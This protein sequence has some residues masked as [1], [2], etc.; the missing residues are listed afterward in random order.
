MNSA[1]L[2]PISQQNTHQQLFT[3]PASNLAK[4]E[5]ASTHA[6]RCYWNVFQVLFDS[7]YGVE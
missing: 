7:W 3:K 2:D 5:T 6:E 4:P 1:L